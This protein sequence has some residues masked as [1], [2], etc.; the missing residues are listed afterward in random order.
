MFSS[1]GKEFTAVKEYQEQGLSI[2]ES[3]S[4]VAKENYADEF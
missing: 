1:A 4:K 2:A 3:I